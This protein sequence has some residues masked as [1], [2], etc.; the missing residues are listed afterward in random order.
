MNSKDYKLIYGAI[1]S[2]MLVLLQTSF[3]QNAIGFANMIRIPY[4]GDIVFL[5][6]SILSFVGA[7]IFTSI[8][9][10]LILNMNKDK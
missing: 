10:K 3:F 1:G 9:I 5:L 4:L 7:I 8:A 2:L 6:S